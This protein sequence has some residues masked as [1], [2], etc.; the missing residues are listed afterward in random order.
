M[1][2]TYYGIRNLRDPVTRPRSGATVSE[3]PAM[4]AQLS[5]D[6]QDRSVS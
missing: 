4:I 6:A 1:T 5:R 2:T 3:R